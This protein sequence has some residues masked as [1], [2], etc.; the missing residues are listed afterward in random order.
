MVCNTTNWTV[1]GALGWEIMM[2]PQRKKSRTGK[3][4]KT[5]PSF[6]FDVAWVR[7]QPGATCGLSLLLVLAL[8]RGFFFG[9][10][11]EDPHKTS[12][13]WYGF[14]SKK[15]FSSL[16]KLI[17]KLSPLSHD[18]ER[19][20]LMKNKQADK[21]AENNKKWKGFEKSRININRN[22]PSLQSKRYHNPIKSACYFNLWLKIK[23]SQ[24]MESCR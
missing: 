23:S 4:K 3:E 21:Q 1:L 19:A 13:L 6:S 9:F 10:K 8:L 12:Y 5:S 24:K 14:L 18:T 17:E 15:F 11:R 22:D 20:L 7:F 16:S 2:L